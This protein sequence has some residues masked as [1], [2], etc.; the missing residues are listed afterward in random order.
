M[1]VNVID[2]ARNEQVWVGASDAVLKGKDATDADVQTLT[3]AIMAKYP[4]S[5]K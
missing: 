4:V 3:D 1:T 5:G 2:T